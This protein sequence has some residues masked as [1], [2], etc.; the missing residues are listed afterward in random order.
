MASTGDFY[1]STEARQHGNELYKKGDLSGAETS[2]QRAAKLAPNDP[3]P[4]SNLSSVKF[5]QGQYA[6]AVEYIHKAI[7]LSKALPSDEAAEKKHQALHLRLAKC[8]VHECRFAE[9]EQALKQVSDDRFGAS[10]RSTSDVLNAWRTCESSVDETEHRRNIINRLPRHKAH[11]QNVFEYYAIGH[12]LAE[13]LADDELFESTSVRDS[14]SF[15]FCGSGDA[16]HVFLTLG[17]LFVKGHTAKRKKKFKNIHFTLV[18]LK[19]A[20]IARTLLFF[21]MFDTYQSLRSRKAPG[22][23]NL[24]TIMA[25]VYAAQVIPAAVNEEIQDHI[26]ALI[27]SLESEDEVLFEWLFVD[28]ATRKQ[29]MYVLKQWQTPL[30]EQASYYRTKTVRRELKR[31]G[32]RG[33][34]LGPLL[35]EAPRSG[36]K[37]DRKVFDELAILLPPK[38]FAE[39]HDPELVP[40]MT[41]YEKSTNNAAKAIGAYI[42]E[43]WVT[44]PTLVDV[45]FNRASEGDWYKPDEAKVP[46][47]AS[48]P[49]ELALNVAHEPG[50]SVLDSLATF[51][52]YISFCTLF[53]SRH[54]KVEVLVGEM[55]DVMD[56]IRWNCLDSRSRPCGGID[57]SGFPKTYDRIHMSNIPDYIGGPLSTGLHGRPLLGENK[58]TNLRFIILLNPPMFSGHEHLQSEYFLMYN[59]KIITDHFGL[60]RRPAEVDPGFASQLA[61]M[62]SMSNIPGGRNAF[63]AERYIVWDQVPTRKLL[64][65]KGLLPRSA[66]EKWLYAHFLKICLPYP[67][68]PMT[69]QPIY[70]PLNLTT[71]LRLV[72]H[73]SSI[74]YPSHWLSGILEAICNGEITTTARAPRQIA[75][76]EADIDAVH[77]AAKMTVTPW[78]ADF[79]TTLGVW[80]R[81]LRFG[82]V[83]PPSSI[84]GPG[85]V[86]EYS[87]SFP[88]FGK[89]FLLKPHF[90]ILF[91]D[92]AKATPPAGEAMRRLLLDD[93]T[94]NRSEVAAERRKSAVHVFSSFHYVE[95]TRTARWWCR[96]D[97]MKSLTGDGSGWKVYIWRTDTWDRVTEGV[98]AKTGV[99]FLGSWTK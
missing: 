17:T 59:D 84:V 56:R 90:V 37:N 57:P 48:D 32:K 30:A 6:A 55:L 10:V 7:E 40:L 79:T 75:T 80:S 44:N 14:L 39:R 18:D 87:V 96:T 25:Y 24:P 11:L 38:D 27:E 70:S 16:R 63:A 72:E 54:M 86:G 93:E 61:H 71:F 88:P 94:G 98:D 8:Y 21:E 51:F 95:N 78:R 50:M 4:L 34:P 83:A 92:T 99:S 9:A 23:E 41:A 28:P 19:P 76:S 26:E 66:L 58:V 47:F 33:N 62:L 3:A 15:M 67:R 20:A 65:K 91:W 52:D 74:G 29:A 36:M 42:D 89:R 5:E 85:D 2:Y 35:K 73:F 60:K 13:P 46:D 53:L 77:P 45:D 68:P 82:F 1:S 97:V 12:D 69:G 64:P 49:L 31:R 43:N 81:L 22:S